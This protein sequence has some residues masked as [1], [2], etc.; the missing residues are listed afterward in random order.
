[1]RARLGGPQAI[2]AAAHKLA[3]II[4]HLLT[5]RTPYDETVFAVKQQRQKIRLH[6]RFSKQA[7]IL[8]FQLVPVTSEELCS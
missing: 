2:T 4:Y 8:G 7:Q 6:K 1:M 3:R 5:T